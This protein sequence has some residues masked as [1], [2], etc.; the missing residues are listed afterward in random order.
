MGA[1]LTIRIAFALSMIATACL[2]ALPQTAASDSSIPTFTAS[3]DLVLVDVIPEYTKTELRSRSI[4]L[5]TDLK[6]EEFRIFDNDK[7]MPISSFDVGSEH[8]TR[9]VALWLIVQC[10][11]GFPKGWA[12]DFLRGRTQLLKGALG[13]LEAQDAVGVA[14]WCD[15]GAAAIDLLP[16]NDPD[17]A[18]ATLDQLLRRKPVDGES[19]TGELAMQKLV[20][21]LVD[22][23]HQTK[24]ERLP[25][26]LFL[27]GDHCATYPNEAEKI[28]QAVLESSGIVF[29]M[30]DGSWLINP[31]SN[32]N[33]YGQ[34]NYLVHH[35]SQ[36]TGGQFYTTTDPKL[37]SAALDY[38]VSQVHLRYTLGFKPRMIDGKRH[39]IRVELTK[40]AQQRFQGIQLRFRQ[41][42]IPI[43]AKFGAIE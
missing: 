2:H 30:S 33:F 41:E 1:A 31:R 40:E 29:G 22:N 24:P 20:R 6:R 12:S 15:N 11:Q 8:T 5:A 4:T 39:T 36:E 9:P 23:V 3:S 38:I 35:Y 32:Y 42:Y 37:F 13:H 34:I 28:I 17:A 7:E 19:R 14:H 43:R 16:G 25:I 27:Y 18:L 26:L 10:P 21:S